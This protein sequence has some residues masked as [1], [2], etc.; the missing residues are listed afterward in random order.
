MGRGH[1]PEPRR[2]AAHAAGGR[3]QPQRIP[4]NLP[5]GRLCVTVSEAH[6]G[7]DSQIKT[8]A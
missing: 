2:G 5:V 7:S 8:E 1:G 4:E 6:P 3:G